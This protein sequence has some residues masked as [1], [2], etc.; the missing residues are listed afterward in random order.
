MKL[1]LFVDDIS[2][3]SSS[4]TQINTF[5]E[6]QK[7]NHQWFA[8]LPKLYE[9]ELNTQTWNHKHRKQLE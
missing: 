8:P 4:K 1:T 6:W 3:Y 5:W 7:K 2:L 9:I